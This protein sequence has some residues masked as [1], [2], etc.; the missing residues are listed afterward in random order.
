VYVMESCPLKAILQ[1][2][3]HCT[4]TNDV[5]IH[6]CM[7]ITALKASACLLQLAADRQ[8]NPNQPFLKLIQ[9]ERDGA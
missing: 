6:Q 7:T 1:T 3:K 4:I 8:V 2:C 9:D 5:L